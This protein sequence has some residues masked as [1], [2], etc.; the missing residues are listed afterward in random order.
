MKKRVFFLFAINFSHFLSAQSMDHP[1]DPLSFHRLE[2]VIEIT[3]DDFDSHPGHFVDESKLKAFILGSKNPRGLLTLDQFYEKG[4]LSREEVAALLAKIETLASG[5]ITTIRFLYGNH[6]GEDMILGRYP[7]QFVPRITGMETRNYENPE[8]RPFMKWLQVMD[9]MM[10]SN[11]QSQSSGVSVGLHSYW[12]PD[13]QLYALTAA[14]SAY[15]WSDEHQVGTSYG[16]SADAQG[17]TASLG[18]SVE[19]WSHSMWFSLASGWAGAGYSMRTNLEDN[20]L[21][22][23]SIGVGASVSG[24]R[25]YVQ[26]GGSLTTVGSYGWTYGVGGAITLGKDRTTNYIKPYSQEYEPDLKA[27]MDAYEQ[28]KKLIEDEILVTEKLLE[29]LS[30]SP[31]GSETYIESLRGEI[32]RLK[33]D[34]KQVRQWLRNFRDEKKTLQDTHLIEVI[35]QDSKALRLNAGVNIDGIG[36]GVRGGKKKTKKSIYRFYSPMERGHELLKDGDGSQFALM[37]LPH[38]F[39]IKG[40]PNIR[41]PHEMRVGEEVITSLD[42][43]FNGNLVVGMEPFPGMDLRA[44]LS[45]TV[46]GTFEVGVRKLPGNKLELSIKPSEIRELGAFIAAINVIG[47]QLTGS[48]TVAM[49]MRMNFVFDL[50]SQ[51]AM[52]VYSNFLTSGILPINFS[53]KDGAVGEEEAINFLDTARIQ[54]IKLREKGI[55]L[56]YLEK[57]DIPAKKF[58]VGFAKV[59]A[60]NRWSG[61]SYEFLKGQAKVVGTDGVISLLRVTGHQSKTKSRGRSGREEQA[62]YATIKKAYMKSN[63]A[64]LLFQKGDGED[65]GYS[66]RFKGLILRAVLADSR[67]TGKDQKKLVETMNT[68]FHANIFPF[69]DPKGETTHKQT[70]EVILE[71]ELESGDFALIQGA[72][73]ELIEEA[74]RAS[75]LSSSTIRDLQADLV[76]KGH[77]QMADVI[78]QFIY[79]HGIK[80]FSAVHLILGGDFR[81][82]VIR[83]S[84]NAYQ[85]PIK[86]ASK[87]A[88]LYTNPKSDGTTRY[89]D[90]HY[91]SSQ[92][93]VEKI[94]HKV[95]H[96]ILDLD[97]ALYDLAGDPFMEGEED[98]V[99]F[100]NGQRQKKSVLRSQILASKNQLLDLI[101]L[102]KQ[103]FDLDLIRHTYRKIHKKIRTLEQRLILLEE[104]FERPIGIQQPRKKIGERWV[105][106]HDFLID[107]KEEKNKYSDEYIE[108][109]FTKIFTYKRKTDLKSLKK[110]AQKL[111]NLDHLKKDGQAFIDRMEK[112]KSKPTYREIASYMERMLSEE[113]T[114]HSNK[115]ILE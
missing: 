45:A 25:D 26:I 32:T 29:F 84:S 47:P 16:L 24:W 102:E 20:E 4:S 73:P 15:H 51:K 61:L 72:G 89:L 14:I 79:D 17:L 55:H 81:K 76:N 87:L 65:D 104:N 8:V 9:H 115:E 6:R 52:D 38:D 39:D 58:Y 62:A 101:D 108:K 46:T 86:K 37:R 12:L 3:Q 41:A 44:G 112:R 99:K 90:I 105:K 2:Q 100:E 69:Y 48:E 94:Y 77:N 92:R 64:D 35:D 36:M 71:R 66:S 67:V 11:P 95:H 97:Q 10:N 21:G 19:D 53:A 1:L 83:T 63:Q 40:F 91:D 50:N 68:M 88:K 33:E 57:M 109:S 59:P 85:D 30:T 18:L 28:K 60:L 7:D 78:K 70:R 56:K 31:E 80:G 111:I 34:K 5:D 114:T 106:V 13:M 74:V 54:Q 22:L 23:S 75:D 43:T 107:V 98:L 93:R 82:L 110:R 96:A 27:Y 42:R 49:I 103:E 113:D